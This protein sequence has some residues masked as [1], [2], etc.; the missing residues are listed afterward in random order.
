[1]S[2]KKEPLSSEPESGINP[3]TKRHSL[4]GGPTSIIN[5]EN[6]LPDYSLIIAQI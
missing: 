5:A 1:M 3:R 6:P 2:N 4:L